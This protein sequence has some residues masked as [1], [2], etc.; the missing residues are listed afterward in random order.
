MSSPADAL[1]P[2]TDDGLLPPAD[3]VL[4][5]EALAEALLV[6]GPPAAQED[7]QWDTG[8]NSTRTSDSQAAFVTSMATSLNSP[9]RFGNV[10]VTGNLG[11]L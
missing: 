3:Y 6:A 1:P 4:S 7:C 5:L 8:W 10:V 2:S 11:A 9:Q